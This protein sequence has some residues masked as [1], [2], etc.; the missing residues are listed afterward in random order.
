MSATS[1]RRFRLIAETL[2]QLND[3]VA[4]VTTDTDRLV[5]LGLNRVNEVLGPLLAKLQLASE[6]GFLVAESD[7]SVTVSLNLE[8][9]FQIRE[10]F[11]ELFSPTPY[12]IL[13]R[14]ATGTV[15]DYAA[16]QLQSYNRLNGGLA[17]KIV[18]I[19]G[20]ITGSAHSDW[21]ISCAAGISI[22]VM[23]SLLEVTASLGSLSTAAAEAESALATIN[24]IIASGSVL[25]VNGKTGTVI[26]SMSDITGLVTALASKADSNHGH[27]I[28]QVSNLQSTLDGILDAGTY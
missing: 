1:N 23:Q 26:L 14:K 10:E 15:N 12:L 28:S 8:T 6:V 27:T 9:T 21:V 2:A 4:S 5:S 20:S 19:N 18:Y 7:T 22:S 11:R 25:S 16:I 17:G 3:D 24:S 13:Q